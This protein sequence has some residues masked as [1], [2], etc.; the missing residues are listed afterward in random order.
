LGN[1]VSLET[2]AGNRTRRL[3]DYLW[4]ESTFS[5]LVFFMRSFII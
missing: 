3:D 1:K 2:L 5:H 4:F